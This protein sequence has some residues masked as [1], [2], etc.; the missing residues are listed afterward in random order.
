MRI[1]ITENQL[2]KLINLNENKYIVYH[3]TNENFEKFDLKKTAQ[4]IIWFTDSLSS[5]QNKTTG[6]NGFGKIMKREITLNNPAGWDEYEKYGIQELK[7]MGYDGVI[8]PNENENDFIVF[9]PKNIHI[10]KEDTNS[11]NEY[12][13]ILY[14]G[15]NH[16]IKKFVNDFIGGSQAADANGPGIYFSDNKSDSEHYGKIIYKT[17]INSNKFITDKNKNGI[18]PS[19]AIK[20][21]KLS[22][23]WEMNAQ[24]W[25]ENPN[26]GL[27]KFIK[28]AFTNNE[29]SKE[30]LLEI[31]VTFYRYKPINF[32]KNC[33]SI[34][35]DG[36]NV[37]NKWGGG[38]SSEHYIIYNP[39]IIEIIDVEGLEDNQ[40]KIEEMAYP[41]S[42][43]MEEFKSINSFA[44]RIR[45]CNQHLN[46]I[47]SG[48]GR[49]IYQIDDEKVLKLAKNQKGIAQNGVEAEGYIQNYDI[50]SKVFDTDDNDTFVEMELARKVT[51]TIFRNVVGF[52]FKYVYPYLFNLLKAGRRYPE[53]SIPPEITEQLNDDEWMIELA[54]LVGDYGMELGDVARLNSYGLVKRDGQDAVVLVDFGLTNS[55]YEEYYS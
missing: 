18:S 22:E 53:M 9:Y 12:G 51:P 20:L 37:T 6:A 43:S 15:T 21:I 36:I 26:I 29:N 34:G 11:N 31:W 44:Q 50:V 19:K 42:F 28:E 10:I 1:I 39:D 35:I 49:I 8:L 4:G 54:N 33:T 30:I 25:D 13:L 32:A 5:I 7:E 14:H 3:T 16:K 41:T 46:R 55:V 17:R 47:N 45:Y 38:G 40:N 48:S 23:D 24:N 2:N 52:D 27:N